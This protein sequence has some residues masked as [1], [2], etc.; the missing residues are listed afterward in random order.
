[1]LKYSSLLACAFTVTVALAQG[2]R[3]MTLVDVLNVPQVRDPQLSP[4]GR[5]VLYVLAESNWKANKRVSHI[6]KINADGTG[7]M[8]LTTGPDGEADPRW[9]PDGK[10]IA[11]VA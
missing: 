5:Q 3:P 6:W 4:D 8:Q 9:S 11:F 1:M 7:A 2:S 10:T